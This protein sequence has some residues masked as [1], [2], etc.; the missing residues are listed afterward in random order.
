MDR[1]SRRQLGDR[2]RPQIGDTSTTLRVHLRPTSLAVAGGRIWVAGYKDGAVEEVD[3]STGQTVGTVGRKRPQRA[4]VGIGCGLGREQPRLDGVADRPGDRLGR[5]DDPGRQWPDLDRV[6]GSSVWVANQYSSSVSRIDPRRNA[7]VRTSPLHGSPT[8]IATARGTT[9]GRRRAAQPAPRRNA[10]PASHAADLDRPGVERRPVAA[11]VRWADAGRARHLQP[12]R[13]AGRHQLVPDLAVCR[14]RSDRQRHDVHVPSAPAHPLL[15]RAT[16]A[17]CGFPPRRSS[18]SFALDRTGARCS[19]GIVGA[20]SCAQ[21]SAATSRAGSSPTRRRAPSRP[22]ARSRTPT[23]STTSRTDMASRFPVPP[24]TPFHDTGLRADSRHRAVQDRERDEREIRYV[25]NP[26]FREWS[27]AAQPDGNP[28]EIALRFGLDAGR[29]VREI[30]QG[31]ADWSPT[32]SRPQLSRAA[33][34]LSGT[35]AR[36]LDP[37][38]GFLPAQHDACHRSTRCASG[39]RSTSPSTAGG[40]CASTAGLSGDAHVPDP[41]AGRRRLP[42]LL[43]V[44]AKPELVRPLAWPGPGP[45]ATPGRRVG[46][47]RYARSPSGAGRTIRPS[48]GRDP[49][50]GD[51]AKAARVP[52]EDAPSPPCVFR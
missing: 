4:R 24:G 11:A 19:T 39:G 51:R 27:H 12:R 9:C 23:S 30:E 5:G 35:A 26:Y 44:H 47:A 13:W 1:R 48:A 21:P 17:G 25:R 50:C 38:D 36:I 3:L 32:T 34:E 6:D 20:E 40:S 8:A 22:A 46:H 28:D 31:R 42:P 45:R 16:A 49:I 2:A 7:V 37:V 15:R 29:R 18:V 43:P 41:A 52:N 10:R 14:S 33:A